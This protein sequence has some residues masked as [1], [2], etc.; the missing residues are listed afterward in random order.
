ML[1]VG[2]P[3]LLLRS[4]R[5][6]RRWAERSLKNTERRAVWN[7]SKDPSE[8]ERERAEHTE[9]GS[10]AGR[11]LAAA[12]AGRD[13]GAGADGHVERKRE[14]TFDR[15]NTHTG[16]QHRPTRHELC[17]V[18]A[19]QF[20]WKSVKSGSVRRNRSLVPQRF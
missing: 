20:P 10:G 11:S 5:C 1:L 8:R 12:A 17:D 15:V 2:E 13:T 18:T 6:R 7:A 14:I 3:H 9:T 16:P 4:H 19:K